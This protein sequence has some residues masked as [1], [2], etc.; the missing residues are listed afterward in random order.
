MCFDKVAAKSR[1]VSMKNA[2][3]NEVFNYEYGFN[4]IMY[5]DTTPHSSINCIHE[6]SSLPL[7]APQAPV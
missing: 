1:L 2:N 4:I 5:K 6:V 3:Y 7:Y